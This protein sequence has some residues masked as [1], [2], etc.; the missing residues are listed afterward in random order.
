MENKEVEEYKR[1]VFKLSLRKKQY[2]IFLDGFRK[3]FHAAPSFDGWMF[4][5]R[6][7]MCL[8]DI[9]NPYTLSVNIMVILFLKEIYV[10]GLLTEYF[11]NKPH[12]YD[13]QSFSN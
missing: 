7:I 5:V 3:K 11:A 1:K 13:N 9:P 8:D 4:F 10:D 12:A 6:D 2:N